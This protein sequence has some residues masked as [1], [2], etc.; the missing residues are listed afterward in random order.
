MALKP[1]RETKQW[2]LGYYLNAAASAGFIVCGSTA[3]SGADLDSD[4]NA[5]TV[6]AACS[7]AKPVGVLMEDF[8]NIDATR[9][10]IN[11]HKPENLVGS[12]ASIL[13]KGWVV[14]NAVYP[15]AAATAFS[16]A[17]LANS[18]YVMDAPTGYNVTHV[19]YPIVG[20]FLSNKDTDGYVRLLVDL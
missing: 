20:K 16:K 19:N 8:V 1:D 4:T 9:Y 14:T 10:H 6:S 15:S 12:K 18:G 13:C 3:A 2:E 7:G 17:V 5:V 11:Q